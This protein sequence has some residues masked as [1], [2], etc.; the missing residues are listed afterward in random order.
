MT[1]CDTH[2][3]ARHPEDSLEE[4]VSTP[5]TPLEIQTGPREFGWNAI[6][7]YLTPVPIFLH[8]FEAISLPELASLWSL[9]L[10]DMLHGAER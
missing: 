6:C 10:G 9:S 3:R 8:L 2:I 4:A 1:S 7:S 5:M